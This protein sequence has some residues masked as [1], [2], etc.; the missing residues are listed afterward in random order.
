[1]TAEAVDGVT[2]PALAGGL[3]HTIILLQIE[4]KRI[5]VKRHE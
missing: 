2:F 4:A 3:Q 5:E 1:M